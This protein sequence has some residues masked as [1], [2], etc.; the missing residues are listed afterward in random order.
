MKYFM[1]NMMGKI[2]KKNHDLGKFYN[3]PFLNPSSIS[4]PLILTVLITL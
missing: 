1:R 4:K 3:F 2:I